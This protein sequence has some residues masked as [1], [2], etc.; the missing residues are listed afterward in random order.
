MQHLLS[1]EYNM[2]EMK[3]KNSLKTYEV[4][5]NRLKAQSQKYHLQFIKLLPMTWAEYGHIFIV[6]FR[7]FP[8]NKIRN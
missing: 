6:N 1:F 3:M 2:N 5:R 4:S 8:T 7:F